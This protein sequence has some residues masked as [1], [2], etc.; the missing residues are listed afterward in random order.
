[1]ENKI[2]TWV[3]ANR[4][5]DPQ[6]L[7]AMIRSIVFMG[8]SGIIIDGKNSCKITPAVSRASVGAA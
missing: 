6:N 2:S 8:I 4:I 5:N 1:M 7:G 3:Y